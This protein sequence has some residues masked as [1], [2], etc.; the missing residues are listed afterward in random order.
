MATDVSSVPSDVACYRV[1]TTSVNNGVIVDPVTTQLIKHSLDAAAEQMGV[2]LRRAAFSPFIY[3]T[4][5]YAGAIYDSG[6]R[7][8]AQMRCLPIFVGTLNFV[9]EAAIRRLGAESF[10]E[11]DVI[12]S[13]FGFDTGSHQNDVTVVMPAFYEGQLIGYAVNKAHHLDVG[14]TS[15]FVTDSTDPWQEGVM[16]PSVRLYRAGELNDDLHRT[17]LANTRLPEAFN[18]DLHAQIAACEVACQALRRTMARYGLD[19]VVA[20]TDALFDHSEAVMRRA[21]SAIPDG[22]YTVHAAADNDGITDD[23]VPYSVTVEIA[24]DEIIVDLSDAAPQTAGPI[25]APLATTVSCVRCAILALLGINDGANEG[26]FRPI[27]IR[28][29]ERTIFDAKMPAPMFMY[30]WPLITA[31]DHIHRALAPAIPESVT[32]QSGNDVGAMLAWGFREDRTYWGDGTNHPGGHGAALVYG[33]GGGP[34]MHI[35]C[36]GTRNCPT[37]VLEA[38]TPFVVEK[39]EMAIDS[40]GI[41]KFRGGPGLDTH[42]RALLDLNVTLP[43][44]RVRPRPSG[45]FGGGDGRANDPVIEFPDGTKKSYLKASAEFVP[46]GALIRLE[47][48]GGGGIGDPAERDPKAILSDIEEGYISEEAARRDYPHAFE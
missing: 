12:V 17:M 19:T 46:K 35:S 26:Y 38:R 40:G 7:L 30:A 41:G 29:R 3:D 36:S 15:M 24:G 13:T 2:A 31:I 37:E 42:Y 43:W 14:A 8:V 23:E 22:V 10:R 48:G 44:E 28:T 9:V 32:A 16:Y 45:L 27:E 47:T 20:G 5:D 4:H 34:V 21:L 18:G 33:D 1:T 39:V 25:N 6:V 11:G